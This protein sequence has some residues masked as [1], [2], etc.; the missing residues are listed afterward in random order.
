MKSL[1]HTGTMKRVRM[2]KEKSE[3]RQIITPNPDYTLPPEVKDSKK[4][5]Q[6]EK[7]SQDLKQFQTDYFGAYLPKK[8][9]VV[10]RKL[11][12]LKEVRVRFK[13]TGAWNEFWP[14]A[15]VIEIL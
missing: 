5:I 14:M 1:I 13:V 6:V 4:Q 2:N 3:Y 9:M 15:K 11:K 7:I 8:L 10:D 12:H